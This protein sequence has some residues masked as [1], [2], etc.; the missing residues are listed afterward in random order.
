MFNS[1]WNTQIRNQR[2]RLGFGRHEHAY[3]G[4]VDFGLN[5]ALLNQERVQK[6]HKTSSFSNSARFE[7]DGWP[8]RHTANRHNAT[9]SADFGLDLFEQSSIR[10]LAAFAQCRHRNCQINIAQIWV[11]NGPKWRIDAASKDDQ[12]ENKPNFWHFFHQSLDA[13]LQFLISE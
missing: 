5:L 1:T 11:W 10:P 4:S 2:S 8:N 9:R 3:I 7:L 12:N 6:W 13:V